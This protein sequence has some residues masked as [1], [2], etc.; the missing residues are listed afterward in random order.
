MIVLNE[1][2]YNIIIIN[3]IIIIYVKDISLILKIFLD[4][5]PLLQPV[6][7]DDLLAEEDDEEEVDK[8]TGDITWDTDFREKTNVFKADKVHN[9]LPKTL[10]VWAKVTDS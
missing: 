5:N 1:K 3:C 8:V 6:D 9:K 4:G 10:I 7:D 2:Y